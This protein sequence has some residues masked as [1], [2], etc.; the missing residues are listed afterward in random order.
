VK[1]S[2]LYAFRGMNQDFEYSN[3]NQ[4]SQLNNYSRNEN[5][6]KPTHSFFNTAPT[7]RLRIIKFLT[8]ESSHGFDFNNTDIK[9]FFGFQGVHP[10][11]EQLIMHSRRVS[12]LC[13]R[14]GKAMGLDKQTLIE[15]KIAGMLHDI[16]KVYI[17]EEIINKPEKLDQSK[18]EVV[19]THTVLGYEILKGIKEYKNIAK[20]ARSHHERIDGKGY[21]DRLKADEIPL[22]SRIIAVADA[23]EAMTESRPY[24]QSLCQK[25]AMKELVL[26][27]GTQFDASIVQVF[28]EKVL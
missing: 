20:Y 21:P 8:Y 22:G 5:I 26:N 17:P 10:L 9:N 7:E 19:R 28:I 11:D 16:G 3:K 6:E 12:E 4:F 2:N 24:R 18:L 25:D 13:V 14:I 1:T 23:Y 15:L 27:A